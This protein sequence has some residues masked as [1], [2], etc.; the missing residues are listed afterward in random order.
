MQTHVHESYFYSPRSS[1]LGASNIFISCF[2]Q[3]IYFWPILIVIL[4]MICFLFSDLFKMIRHDFENI[5]GDVV[6]KVERGASM[7][8]II[9]TFTSCL[10][11]LHTHINFIFTRKLVVCS[12]RIKRKTC[13]KPIKNRRFSTRSLK[14]FKLWVVNQLFSTR[15]GERVY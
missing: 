14:K 9:F 8:L 7:Y 11:I 2:G 3:S 10:C 12:S 4:H 15:R 5:M 6:M 1:A 13:T